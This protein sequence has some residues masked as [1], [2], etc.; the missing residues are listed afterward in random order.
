MQ[1]REVCGSPAFVLRETTEHHRM[2]RRRHCHAVARSR[3]WCRCRREVL[4]ASPGTACGVNPPQISELPVAPLIAARP[5]TSEHVQM[6]SPSDDLMGG[7]RLRAR[8]QRHGGIDLLPWQRLRRV[9]AV[10]VQSVQI[11]VEH[12]FPAVEGLASKKY[13][14]AT[15]GGQRTQCQR[16]MASGPRSQEGRRSGAVADDEGPFCR[17]DL[18]R[19]GF[20]VVVVV[21]WRLRIVLQRL[22][23]RLWQLLPGVT[24]VCLFSFLLIFSGLA[25]GGRGARFLGSALCP[26]LLILSLFSQRILRRT[27]DLRDDAVDLLLDPLENKRR[28]YAHVPIFVG[29]PLRQQLPHLPLLLIQCYSWIGNP[30]PELLSYAVLHCDDVFFVSFSN[31]RRKCCR[32]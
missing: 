7:S 25:H 3:N 2:S 6:L 8:N 20:F 4:P 17:F 15:A 29:M 24:F 26:A 9:S 16:E 13:Q 27:M 1:V 28:H 21:L 19:V 12:Q 30:N 31:I 11:R 32:R 14:F 23:A 10:D 18:V 22:P 5:L